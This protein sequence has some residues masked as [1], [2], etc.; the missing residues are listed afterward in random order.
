VATTKQDRYGQVSPLSVLADV[1]RQSKSR[2]DLRGLVQ[3]RDETRG[4]IADNKNARALYELQYQQQQDN[5][6]QTNTENSASA[7]VKAASVANQNRVTADALTTQNKVDAASVANQ[8][9]MAA[10]ELANQN[11]VAAAALPKGGHS[12]H[13]PNDPAKTLN[14]LKDEAGNW[15]DNN[16]TPVDGRVID[17]LTPWKAGVDGSK[18]VRS[19]KQPVDPMSKVGSPFLVS[20][21]LN[22]DLLE[23]ATG[24]FDPTQI[25]ASIGGYNTPFSGAPEQQGAQIQA[26]QS[27]MADVKIDSVKT[28]LEGLGINPTDKDLAIALESI[29]DKN[30]QPLAW[31][32]WSRD[33]FLPMLRKAGWAS[34]ERG[35]IGAEDFK[36]MLAG[37]EKDINTAFNRYNGEETPANNE[38]IAAQ[39]NAATEA[40]QPVQNTPVGTHTNEQLYN[41]SD[42]DFAAYRESMLGGGR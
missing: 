30:T 42:E 32:I 2:K 33:Q 11:K 38:V 4:R 9:Q 26:L 17:N 29:P 23:K 15:Y 7:L 12:F 20:Q 1:V 22:N 40:Q 8:N 6:A 37:A 35:T 21:I 5:Q 13:N 14:Y 39:T 18:A 3:A 16:G 10:Y 28:N 36:L 31:A 25:A 24:R 27:K 41:M 19:G 34:V